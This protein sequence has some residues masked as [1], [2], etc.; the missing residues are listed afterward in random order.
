MPMRVLL[1]TVALLVGCSA[2]PAPASGGARVRVLVSRGKEPSIT[3]EHYHLLCAFS[4]AAGRRIALGVDV[5]EWSDSGG[6]AGEIAAKLGSLLDVPPLDIVEIA[7]GGPSRAAEIVL[8]AGV[9]LCAA[10]GHH[11][12]YRC[13]ADGA[14]EP[15]ADPEVRL[16][17]STPD[18]RGF[19]VLPL[20]VGRRFGSGE[21][22]P[23]WPPA[24]AR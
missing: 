18:G 14:E 9:A 17:V 7:Q 4:D 24:G 10:P 2:R 5:P 1:C 21:P 8:P 11:Y 3:R 15:D 12:V 13:V 16:A 22:I 6:I 19:A 23:D 20:A